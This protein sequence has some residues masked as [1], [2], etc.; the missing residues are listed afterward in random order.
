MQIEEPVV[1]R[2]TSAIHFHAAS[3]GMLGPT[4]I[5]DQVIEVREPGEKHLLTA[6]WMVKRFHH[7]QL[8]RDGVV[9]LVSQRAG[10]G[11]L[12]VCRDRIPA[13]LLLLHP[14]PGR[15]PEPCG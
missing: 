7:A 10:H 6:L 12:V 1:C 15:V 13:R 8:P 3:P 11:R 2:Y 9:G 5:G 14:A 4:L